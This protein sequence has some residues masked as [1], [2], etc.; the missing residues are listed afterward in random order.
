MSLIYVWEPKC[1]EA[2]APLIEPALQEFVKKPFTREVPQQLKLTMA[3][4]FREGQSAGVMPKP[5]RIFVECNYLEQ[6]MNI[7]LFVADATAAEV[8][9]ELQSGN[10]GATALAEAYPEYRD[11]INEHVRTVFAGEKPF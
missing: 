1:S 8:L 3:S 4:I 5:P 10:A 7:E 2:M 11:V 9:H 6:K